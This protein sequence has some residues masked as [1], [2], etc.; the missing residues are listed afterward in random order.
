[1][2][3]QRSFPAIRFIDPQPS[4]HRAA[5]GGATHPQAGERENS[6]DNRTMHSRMGPPATALSPGT[7]GEVTPRENQKENATKWARRPQSPQSSSAGLGGAWA[8]AGAASCSTLQPQGLAGQGHE[9]SQPHRRGVP[10]R[11]P[12]EL[13]APPQHPLT[14]GSERSMK[15]QGLAGTPRCPCNPPSPIMSP[16]ATFPGTSPKPVA[17]HC[18]LPPPSG[19]SGNG[20]GTQQGRGMIPTCAWPHGDPQVTAPPWGTDPFGVGGLHSRGAVLPLSPHPPS[21][22]KPGR[23]IA[24]SPQATSQN[25]TTYMYIYTKTPK[26]EVY[27]NSMR[28]LPH[29]NSS[30]NPLK[31]GQ[32]MG[33]ETCAPTPSLPGTGRGQPRQGNPAGHSSDTGKRRRGHRAGG[34]PEQTGAPNLHG[35]RRPVGRYR[36]GQMNKQMAEG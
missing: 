28:G 1:M 2:Q 25:T 17:I 4:L 32:E 31:G 29:T 13:W 20:A 26:H 30:R 27:K 22:T 35:H 11:T 8:L 3:G 24:F 19:I 18:Q 5:G 36:T 12:P 15:C 33:Q 14:G 7:G 16:H 6:H 9:H 10:H 34:Q 23:S 21:A